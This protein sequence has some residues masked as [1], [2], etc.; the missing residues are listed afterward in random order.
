MCLQCTLFWCTFVV[1]VAPTLIKDNWFFG[2]ILSVQLTS[3]LFWLPYSN[4]YFFFTY[5]TVKK[6]PFST[7]EKHLVGLLPQPQVGSKW[8]PDCKSTAVTFESILHLVDVQ[9]MLWSIMVESEQTAVMF[10]NMPLTYFSQFLVAVRSQE[11]PN[12]RKRLYLVTKIHSDTMS[13]RYS[14]EQIPFQVWSQIP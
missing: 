7:C 1:C 2:I 9:H 10:L 3:M 5:L 14:R 6:R 13:R 12:L 4:I 8:A 11:P